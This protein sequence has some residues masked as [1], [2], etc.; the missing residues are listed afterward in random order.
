MIAV[1]RKKVYCQFT[2]VI[3]YFVIIFHVR[4]AS[5]YMYHRDTWGVQKMHL[6]YKTL[7]FVVIFG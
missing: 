3:E 7:F 1:T 2:N 6:N 4:C 5:A